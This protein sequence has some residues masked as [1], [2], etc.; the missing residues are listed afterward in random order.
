M[1]KLD[2]AVVCCTSTTCNTAENYINL[3]SSK[4]Y[5]SRKFEQENFEICFPC[6][7]LIFLCHVCMLK[8]PSD[9]L[10]DS[11]EGTLSTSLTHHGTPCSHSPLLCLHVKCPIRF[12]VGFNK[13]KEVRSCQQAKH[14]ASWHSLSACQGSRQINCATK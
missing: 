10:C 13:L 5:S 12:V 7:V 1:T 6:Y 2:F 8:V 4:C 3:I 11:E 9:L 14:F